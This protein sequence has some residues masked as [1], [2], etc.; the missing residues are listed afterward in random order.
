MQEKKFTSPTDDVFQLW[1]AVFALV[2]VDGKVSEPEKHYIQTI[3]N[4]FS[5]SKKQHA[6]IESDLEQEASAVLLFSEI[7]DQENRR[8]FFVM[9]RTIMWCDGYLHEAEMGT[10]KDI[11]KNLGEEAKLYQKELR[12]MDRKPFLTEGKEPD[13]KEQDLIQLVVKKMAAFY[14]DNVI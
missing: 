13:E 6:K 4:I 9:A 1:R 5:F 14:E 2:H 7:N 11:V 3:Q 10:I 8:Q 12:W